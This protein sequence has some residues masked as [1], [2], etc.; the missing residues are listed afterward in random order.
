LPGPRAKDD[1]ERALDQAYRGAPVL[2]LYRPRGSPELVLP[3]RDPAPDLAATCRPSRSSTPAPDPAS[4]NGA[5][6]AIPSAAGLG[7]QDRRACGWL[8]RYG[9]W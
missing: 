3:A 1:L 5:A 4:P 8:A 7:V 2:D 6:M 9:P